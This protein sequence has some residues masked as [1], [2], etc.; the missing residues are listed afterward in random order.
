[1][2]YNNFFNKVWYKNSNK[3]AKMQTLNKRYSHN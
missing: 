1:M 2:T 3:M